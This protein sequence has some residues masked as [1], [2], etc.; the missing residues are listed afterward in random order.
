MFVTVLYGYPLFLHRC[1]VTQKRSFI[2]IMKIG[3]CD[4]TGEFLT[5]Q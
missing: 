5:K 2:V 3:G 4:V 1:Y